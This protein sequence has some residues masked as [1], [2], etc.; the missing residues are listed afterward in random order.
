MMLLLQ[1]VHAVVHFTFPL[2]DQLLHLAMVLVVLPKK[3]L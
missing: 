3:G 2:L 1:S